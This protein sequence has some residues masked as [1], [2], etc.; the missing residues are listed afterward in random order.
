MRENKNK[1]V[2]RWENGK[3]KGDVVKDGKRQ[4]MKREEGKWVTG[5]RR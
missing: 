5:T 2:E 3:S 4:R 1:K